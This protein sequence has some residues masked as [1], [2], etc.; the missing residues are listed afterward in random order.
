MKHLKDV[1]L[2]SLLVINI[3]IGSVN[4]YLNM[5]TDIIVDNNIYENVLSRD[6]MML[7]FYDPRCENCIETTEM[8]D[9]YIEFGY[10]QFIDIELIDITQD[11][12]NILKQYQIEKHQITNVPAVVLLEK[13]KV[14]DNVFGIDKIFELLDTIVSMTKTI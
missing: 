7:Y 11:Y 12:S 10:D 9:A 3:L 5:S 8:I 6:A 13:G 2:F 1:F 14:I 4:L